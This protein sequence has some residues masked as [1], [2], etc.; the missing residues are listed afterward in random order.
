M[1]PYITLINQFFEIEQKIE[2]E[3]LREKFE[4][5]FNR[6][7]HTFAQEGYHVLNPL[8]ETYS[9]SRADYEANIAGEGKSKYIITKVIKPIIYQEQSGSRFLVQK[10]VVIAE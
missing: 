1:H 3:Q 2:L 9:E 5:H 4:R 6:I 7:Q 8:G 10:G